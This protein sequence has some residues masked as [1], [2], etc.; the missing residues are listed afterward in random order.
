M[1]C[2]PLSFTNLVQRCGCAI[3]SVRCV[4]AWFRWLAVCCVLVLLGSVWGAL[5]CGVFVWVLLVFPLPDP[6]RLRVLEVFG[7]CNVPL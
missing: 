3:D 7:Y 6:I 5:V 4:L 2:I 1:F